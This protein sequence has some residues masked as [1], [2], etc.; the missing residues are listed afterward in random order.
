MLV[1]VTISALR[2]VPRSAAADDGKWLGEYYAN[3]WRMGP[4][5]LIRTTVDFDWGGGQP[6]P[7]IPDDY[8][9]VRWTRTLN[10][11]AGRYRFTTETDGD[12]VRLF[13][14]GALIIDEWHDQAKT[15]YSAERDLGAGQHSL[16][17]EYY[18][19]SGGS[20]AAPL[21][22]AHRR[23]APA[24]TAWRPLARRVFRQPLALRLAGHGARR[25]GDRLQLE[26][27]SAAPQIPQD[28]FSVR[29]TRTSTFDAGRYRFT[30]VTDDGVRLYLDG[31]LIIDQ[32]RDQAETA[33]SAERDL[34]AGQHSLRMEYYQA[35][36]DSRPAFVEVHDPASTAHGS[37]AGEYFD[38]ASLSGSP[39]RC[40]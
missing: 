7:Q 10:L 2:P 36:G 16:R 38:D 35:S 21:M 24:P 13:L 26:R 18:Q 19:A 23:A 28:N 4:A 30:T 9:S 5:A 29:W 15:A 40:G 6:A 8:F 17:M 22:E 3:P 12:G 14:D 34:G 1:A 20:S 11:D 39:R 27:Q 32:W 33:L 37:L 25:P 31:K